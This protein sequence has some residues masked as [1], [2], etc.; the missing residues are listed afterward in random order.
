MLRAF[1]YFFFWGFREETRFGSLPFP[2]L[3][4]VWLLWLSVIFKHEGAH[5]KRLNAN[6]ISYMKQ[7][8]FI[9]PELFFP[10]L[11]TTSQHTPHTTSAHTP[12]LAGIVPFNIQSKEWGSVL[13]TVATAPKAPH[14]PPFLQSISAH[15]RCRAEPKDSSE[16]EKYWELNLYSPH[17]N[18]IRLIGAKLD[19]KPYYQQL[20]CLSLWMPIPF[21]C[22]CLKDLNVVYSSQNLLRYTHC[23]CNSFS[24][25]ICLTD[26]EDTSP[27]L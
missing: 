6:L 17:I 15:S 12:L 20:L 5:L 22:E 7:S 23:K 10:T 16:I 11:Q 19:D 24:L 3:R 9:F 1:I 14:P 25:C 8:W 18:I 2:I 21:F 27:L 13:W 26:A 4:L